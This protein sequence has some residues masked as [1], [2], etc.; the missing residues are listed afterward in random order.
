M[1][2]FTGD[3]LKINLGDWDGAEDAV[4]MEGAGLFEG[5]DKFDEVAIGAHTLTYADG[6]WSCADGYELSIEDDKMVL[7]KG[8]LA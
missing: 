1:Q 6:V 5:F 7:S 2:D 3:T 8:T 4:L